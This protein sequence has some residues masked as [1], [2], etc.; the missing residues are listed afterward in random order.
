[1]LIKGRK[2]LRLKNKETA[3]HCRRMIVLTEGP[4]CRFW[5]KKGTFDKTL[6]SEKGIQCGDLFALHSDICC[7]IIICYRL[8]SAGTMNAQPELRCQQLN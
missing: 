5:L 3:P 4:Y 8:R 2:T 6:K 1:V 7:S